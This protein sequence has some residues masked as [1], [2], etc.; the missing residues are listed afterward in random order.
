MHSNTT[1]EFVDWTPYVASLVNKLYICMKLNL[2]VQIE[3]EL[4]LEQL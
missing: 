2:I 4:D 3:I 1:K